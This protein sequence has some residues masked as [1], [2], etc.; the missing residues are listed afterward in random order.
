MHR[1]LG[2]RTYVVCWLTVVLLPAAAYYAVFAGPLSGFFFQLVVDES[3]YL[4]SMRAPEMGCRTVWMRKPELLIL[5]DSHSYAAWDFSALEHSTRLRVGSCALGGL[6]LES[7]PALMDTV[8]R[9]GVRPSVIV[10]GLSPRMFWESPTK[11]EQISFHTL[12]FGKLSSQP[13]PYLLS[14]LLGYPLPFEDEAERA[15][16]ESPRIE[17]L[18]EAAIAARLAA[19]ESNLPTLVAWRERLA[20]PT[21]SGAAGRIAP[22]ICERVRA[23]GARL[24][25]IHIPE[26]PYLETKYPAGVLEKYRKEVNEF[27]SCAS[28]VALNN[29]IDYG[30]GNRHYVNRELDP[31]LD[32]SAWDRQGPMTDSRYFDADHMNPIG[33]RVFTM[34]LLKKL[35]LEPPR[36]A[37]NLGDSLGL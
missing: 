23:F 10:L 32:L 11:A 18:D 2:F 17:Q 31:T 27:N 3:S 22:L 5:G 24:W 13:A 28:R 36:Y 30:L 8:F 6:Y 15:T 25:L 26:S 14:R 35:Q 21:Y 29:A 16:K 20:R 33:A 1:P 9:P 37:P 19:S 12:L 7:L 34:S 4:A